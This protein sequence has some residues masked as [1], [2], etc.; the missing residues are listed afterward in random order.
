MLVDMNTIE[1]MGI[2]GQNKKYG[3]YE[4]RHEITN[5]MGLRQAWMQTSL[6]IR[7]V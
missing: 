5:I 2:H 4:P 7:A 3:L 1:I 6:R